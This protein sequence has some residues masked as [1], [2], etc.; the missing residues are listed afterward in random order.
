[1]SFIE[2][3]SWENAIISLTTSPI[4]TQPSD[5]ALVILFFLSIKKYL[6]KKSKLIFDSEFYTLF[7]FFI[8][9]STFIG[10]L[11]FG[12][13]GIA[14]FRAVFYFLIIMVFIATNVDDNE[15]VYLIKKIS[16]YIIPLILLAPINLALTGNFSINVGNRQF[17][18]LMY[19]SIV[20][21]FIAGIFYNRFVD[22]NYKLPLYLLPVFFL[23]LPYTAHRT[24]W[25][26]IIF[27]TPFLFYW[28]GVKRLLFD[29]AVFA[30]V[31]LSFL[32]I[33]YSYFQERLTAFTAFENDST[34]AWRLLI[35]NAIIEDATIFG[36]GIGARFVVFADTI[37]FDASYGA[38]NGFILIL[39]YL[40]YL[41]VGAVILLFIYFL[42]K[43]LRNA[44]KLKEDVI[45]LTIN[46]IGFLG[47]LSLI[48]FMIGYGFDLVGVIFISFAL[49]YN[50]IKNI[51]VNDN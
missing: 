35:W 34:G 11:R 15:V 8:L 38:H 32:T 51:N 7:T 50:T 17:G 4:R 41:G 29:L 24:T 45:A 37:G 1:M 23:M 6:S 44:V 47:L 39:Y 30:V 21:G 19:E 12:Y 28:L 13:A 25:G 48:A 20:V 40:G 3:N 16:S 31:P 14:E 18:A 10:V 27:I 46:R 2:R 5:I 9:T 22:S 33:D 43:T 36:K 49:K 26:A 42:S